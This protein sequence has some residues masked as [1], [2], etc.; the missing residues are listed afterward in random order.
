M[1]GESELLSFP[2]DASED[3]PPCYQSD[4]SE[5]IG[6]LAQLDSAEC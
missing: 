5:R 3:A 2:I 1:V 6:F 4:F